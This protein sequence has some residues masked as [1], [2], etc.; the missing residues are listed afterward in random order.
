MFTLLW[1]FLYGAV[2][3]SFLGVCVQRL[4]QHESV[5]AAWRSMIDTPSHCDRCQRRL[6]ARDNVP[7]FGWL[8]LGGRCRFCKR[9]IPGRYP[10]IELANGLLFVLVY[11]MEVPLSRATPITASCLSCT[12]GP[13]NFENAWGMSSLAMVN[14]RFVY[15][16]VLVEAL[17]VASLIDWDLMIIPDS[18][19]LP[20]MIIGVVGAG[21]FG[22][23]WLVPVWFQDSSV[24]RMFFSW[25]PA[26]WT[27]RW[28]TV[29]VPTWIGEHPHWHG[30]AVSLAGFLV[31][32][33][34]VW[35]VRIVGQI[36][37]RREAMGFGDVVLMAM[38]GSFVGWQPVVVAFFVAPMLALVAVLLTRLFDLSRE[39]PYGPYLSLGTLVTL[40]GWKWIWPK[41]AMYFSLGPM[42]IVIALTMTAALLPTLYLFR[43]IKRALGLLDD[44]D[45]D[46]D[47][48][49][50]SADQLFHF[51]GETVDPH[52]G[53]WHQESWPG[54][55]AGRGQSH[56]E[57]WQ[58]PSGSGGQQ[59]WTR[60]R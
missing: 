26:R 52:Q 31:G 50:T 48:E 32:G 45:H 2:L 41:V 59:G 14:W 47:G 51:S 15:H 38:V 42:L 56:V 49:W 5:F 3:G 37:L 43:L 36:A 9:G 57:Q 10:L 11:A 23:F 29:S 6:L 28:L 20:P 18:V 53:Q 4:P 27:G 39:I 7:I 33:G 24:A 8:L 22:K 54:N 12:M 46:D 13:S 55:A 30:L 16:L 21:T 1:L 34:I 40:L 58:R 25:L 17:F 19:T 44:D 35:A 60:H